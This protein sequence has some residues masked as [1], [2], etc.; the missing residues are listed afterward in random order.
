MHIFRCLFPIKEF[1]DVRTWCVCVTDFVF[2]EPLYSPRPCY[3]Y[4]ALFGQ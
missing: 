3:I 2:A 1:L 4:Y